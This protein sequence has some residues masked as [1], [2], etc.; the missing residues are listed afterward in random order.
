MAHSFE[1]KD[2]LAEDIL[3]MLE[4]GSPHDIK[5]K[6]SDGEVSANKDIL[7]ARS[8]Y[9]KAMLSNKKFIEEVDMSHCSKA[10]MAKIIKFLFSGRVT[11]DDL[12][13]IQLNKLYVMSNM[14]LLSEIKVK[15]NDYI[16]NLGL[17]PSEQVQAKVERIQVLEKELVQKLEQTK[18]Q[19]EEL[20][21]EL[22]KE[23]EKELEQ[24]KEQIKKLKKEGEQEL[25]TNERLKKMMKLMKELEQDKVQRFRS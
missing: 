5:I 1:V 11:F 4:E 16:E 24:A 22:G 2:T 9:F 20:E 8:V 14:M 6:V 25:Q 18:E 10:V 13:M 12:S 15:V 17:E 19:R 23:L 7:M 21:K 3:K